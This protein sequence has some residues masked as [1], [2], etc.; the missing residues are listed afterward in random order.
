MPFL[1]A[2]T[3]D[4]AADLRSLA[5]QRRYGGG[6]TVFH[7]DDEAG[8]GAGLLAGRGKGGFLPRDGRE[9]IVAV[10]GPGDVVGELAAL[11]E[12]PRQ[13]TVVTLEPVEALL[14]V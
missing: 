7:Q 8:P 2:L 12:A 11:A 13:A 14:V 6:V 9:V 3:A 4:E 10:R 5:H 1:E